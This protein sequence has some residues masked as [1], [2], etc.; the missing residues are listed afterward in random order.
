MNYR[1][2]AQPSYILWL[3]REGKA[4]TW[5][6]L[7]AHF[8]YD[9]RIFSGTGKTVLAD[10]LDELE[11]AGL[12]IREREEDSLIIK[13]YRYSV[14]PLVGKI[15]VALGI[16]ISELAQNAPHETLIVAPIFGVPNDAKY[17]YDLFVLMPFTLVLEPIYHDHIK[18]VAQQ[19]EMKIARADDFFTTKSIMEEIWSAIVQSKIMIADCTDK[20]PNVFY[21]IGIAH[22]LGKPVIL[23][24][25][26]EDDVPFDLRHM[27]CIKYEYTSDGME[28]FEKKLKETLSG[29]KKDDSM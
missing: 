13:K 22:T 25:Q 4:N 24:T 28:E 14:A 2:A 11:D 1:K 17:T 29:L 19:L 3:I 10:S 26:K 9:E 27:R 12:I 7:L 20:N 21:E 18:K 23:L 5:E 6:E 16:S 8:N 15:Q